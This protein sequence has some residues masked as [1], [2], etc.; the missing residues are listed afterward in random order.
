[1][2]LGLEEADMDGE[3]LAFGKNLEGQLGLGEADGEELDSVAEPSKVRWP[4]HAEQGARRR[5]EEM[6]ADAGGHA[7]GVAAA[8]NSDD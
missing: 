8:A 5:E 1:M 2:K 7:G 3:L 4:Q 6:Q